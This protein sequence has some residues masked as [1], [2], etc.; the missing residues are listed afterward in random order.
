MQFHAVARHIF[1]FDQFAALAQAERHDVADVVRSRDDRS[2]DV[3]FLDVVDLHRVGHTGG[4]VHL[5]QRVVLV[6]DIVTH[7]RHRGDHIHVELA[8]ET[9]LHDFHVQQSEE[10]AA[11]TEAQGHRRFGLEGERGVV[12]LELF[13]RSA[14]Q[15]EVFRFDGVDTGE[16]HR[17]H[18]FEARNGLGAGAFHR[19]DCVAHLDFG[20][21]FDT[22]H[23]VAHVAAAQGLSR[24]EIHLQ[25]AHFVGLIL[26]FGVHEEHVLAALD[27]TVYDFEVGDDAAIGI[28]HRVE[29]QSLERRVGIAFGS[30]NA[31]HNSAEDVVNPLARL[32]RSADDLFAFATD[33]FDDFVFHLLGHG[34]R[35]V[36][37]V[38][39]GNDFE[40]VLD[41]H[42]EVRDGLRLYALCR[43]DHEQTAFA[44][45]DGAAHFVGKVHVTRGVDEVE[46]IVLSVQGVVHL[47]GVTFDGD[48]SFFFEV[49]IVEHLSGRHFDGL[50]AFEQSVGQ[51]TFSVV[52]VGNDAEIA[53][54]VH[55]P[56]GG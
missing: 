43:V 17:L 41:G 31:F 49:H 35:H 16:N 28:E 10:T 1:L 13:E 15:F 21:R 24:R 9:L 53:N 38:E 27:R 20:G 32:T 3:R 40:V 12:E 5:D 2:A 47:D 54:V 29:D 37:L 19:S 50:S 26:A 23:D 34:V 25:H 14:E 48:A 6:V 46:H 52:D 39:H 11:E 33:E 30:G 18:L 51:G 36:A 8:I 4:V 22:A 56:C 45:R 55:E 44:G 42:V 7:V